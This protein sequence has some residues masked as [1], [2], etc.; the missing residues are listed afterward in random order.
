MCQLL[1]LPQS[2]F[3]YT[4]QRADD[5]Q[6]RT[7][8]ETICP[9][10]P[11]HGHRRVADSLNRQGISIGEEKVCR[12][13][14]E[15]GLLVRPR[16]RRIQ[17][18]N[19]PKGKP[20]YPNRIKGLEIV[21]PNQ[22]ICGDITYIPSANGRTAY[23]AIL[24]DVFTRMIRGWELAWHMSVKLVDGALDKA[25]AK[26]IRPEIHHADHGSQYI[27]QSYCQRLEALGCQISSQCQPKVVPGK[28]RML[29]ASL[30]IS[31]MNWSGLRSSRISSMPIRR[32]HIS[33]MWF[34]IMSVHIRH[35]GI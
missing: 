9:A 18:T 28:I 1:Q 21:R 33:S 23:L 10:K 24:I 29:K 12:L 11:R 13:M 4:P 2:S 19:S 34:I 32:F 30:G 31:K 35:W 14:R 17:T 3:Y 26:G 27:A 20:L 6:I 15:M 25:L 22:V 5:S 16:R 7:A 8:I